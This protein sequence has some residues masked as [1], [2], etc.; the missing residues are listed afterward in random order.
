MLF[1]KYPHC[2]LQ[3]SN[4]NVSVKTARSY[5]HNTTHILWISLLFLTKGE[6]T[7]TTGKSTIH[8]TRE[9]NSPLRQASSQRFQCIIKTSC[10]VNSHLAWGIAA[11][12][13]PLALHCDAWTLG[14]DASSTKVSDKPKQCNQYALNAKIAVSQTKCN[15]WKEYHFHHAMN[16]DASSTKT[17]M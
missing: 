12:L 8:C 17:T 3:R 6:H 15:W 10:L 16:H 1:E 13:L 7:H 9:S 5:D 11:V 2:G 4:K 14:R